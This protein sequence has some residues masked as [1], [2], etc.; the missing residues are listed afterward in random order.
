MEMKRFKRALAATL[1]ASLAA[2]AWIGLAPIGPAAA[3]VVPIADPEDGVAGHPDVATAAHGHTSSRPLKHTITTYEAFG[4]PDSPCLQLRAL[5]P[6]RRYE[7]C[8]NG[9]ITRTSDGSLAGTATVGRPDDHTVEYTFPRKALDKPRAYYWRVVARD[10][11]CPDGICDAAPDTAWVL[12]KELIT[13]GEWAAAFLGEMKAPD[14]QNNLTVV[15]AWEVNEGTDAVFNPLATT[16]PMPG[17]TKFNSVGVRNYV[18]LAQGLDATRLTIERG[19]S[20][21]GYGRIV[22]RLRNCAPARRTARAI[23]RSEWCGGCSDGRYV[24]GLIPLVESDYDTY[25]ARFISTS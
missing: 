13:Y 8:G 7:L 18:S 16:Y 4:T 25:A 1:A 12:H 19:W 22:T 24:I 23:K 15:V 10:G 3:D 5:N 20:S 9:R 11:D 14:C 21:Y 17:A 6:Q 2:G